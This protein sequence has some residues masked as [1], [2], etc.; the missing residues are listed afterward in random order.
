[1][2]S[3]DQLGGI[4]LPTI[5]DDAAIAGP[6][7]GLAAALDWAGKQG[8]DAALTIPCDMPC[9]PDDLPLRLEASLGDHAAALAAS[10]NHLHPV[11]GLW[12][13]D[14]LLA[15]PAY[16][17]SGRRSLHGFAERVGFARVDWP[18]TPADPFFNINSPDD[19]AEAE[20][21]LGA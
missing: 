9:L 4:A 1:L 20:R 13:T 17:A 10:G 7:A 6:L 12:R 11:C 19:L 5:I 15:M 3:A 2:R 18:A 8:A 16:C 21:L 14:G